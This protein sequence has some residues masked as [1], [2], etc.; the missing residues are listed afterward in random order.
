MIYVQYFNSLIKGNIYI[1]CFYRFIIFVIDELYSQY[2]TNHFKKSFSEK[3]E[4]LSKENIPFGYF[5]VLNFHVY[6]IF[7]L[8]EE[9]IDQTLNID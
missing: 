3:Q 6:Q 9:Y 4:K 7:K 5:I 1:I 8:K 2:L